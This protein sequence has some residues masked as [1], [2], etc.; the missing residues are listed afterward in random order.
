[1]SSG[2]GYNGQAYLSNEHII[3]GYIWIP[4]DIVIL[5]YILLTSCGGI[6]NDT[7]LKSTRRMSSRQGIMK[8]IPE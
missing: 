5:I 1:M 3:V 2:G 4:G 8:N 6:S 7:V